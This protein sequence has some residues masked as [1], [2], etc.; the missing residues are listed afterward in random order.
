MHL[1]TFNPNVWNRTFDKSSI[2]GH[3]QSITQIIHHGKY[4]DFGNRDTAYKLT[5]EGCNLNVH[6]EQEI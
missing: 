4:K 1:L 5:L 3:F 2:D 6:T